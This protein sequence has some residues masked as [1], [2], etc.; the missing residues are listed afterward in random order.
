MTKAGSDRRLV[1]TGSPFERTHGYSRAVIAGGEVHIAGTTGYD[2]AAMTMPEDA[3]EQARNIYATFA[4]V[5][6]IA[7]TRAFEAVAFSRS[8]IKRG[9]NGRG[10]RFAYI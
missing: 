8:A 7:F 9:V 4:A 10:F 5:L 6:K 3:A 1:S 2:Y